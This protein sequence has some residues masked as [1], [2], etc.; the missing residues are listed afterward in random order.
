MEDKF[1][2]IYQELCEESSESI[3]TAKKERNK[4]V[5]TVFIICFVINLII[6]IIDSEKFLLAISIVISVL[7]ILFIFDR[8]QRKFAKIFKENVISAMVKKCN[9][10]LNFAFD[11][12]ISK[13]EYILSRFDD[14]FDE[15]FSEDKI[16]GELENNE[17]FQMAQLVTKEVKRYRDDNGNERTDRTETFRGLYG[18]VNLNK[19]IDSEILISSNSFTKK[20]SAKRVEMDSAEFEEEYDCLTKDRILAMKIFTSDLLEKFVDLKI[21]KLNR[22][23]FRI[24][25]DSIYFRIACGELFEPPKFKEG[26]NKD[27]IRK[28]YNAIFLPIEIIEKTIEKIEML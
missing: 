1:D 17:K 15:M 23:L 12:G 16:Y 22:I 8:Q 24:E 26:L 27:V 18:I 3:N 7:I 19:S 20:Y 10:K 13:T 5:F 28:Y 9:K 2:E 14:S 11:R 25:D 4:N 6:G 21:V